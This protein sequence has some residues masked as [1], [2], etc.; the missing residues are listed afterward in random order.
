VE[1]HKLLSLMRQHQKDTDGMSTAWEVILRPNR[2]EKKVAAP[3]KETKR[4][5]D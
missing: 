3:E 2:D 1:V 5:S 4:S